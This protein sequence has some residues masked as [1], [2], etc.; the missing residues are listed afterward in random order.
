MYWGKRHFQSYPWRVDLPIWQAVVAEFFLLRTRASQVVP[1]FERFRHCYPDT[2]TL[3]G[4]G[5]AELAALVRPLG[6]RWREPLFYQL[7]LALDDLGD[8]LADDPDV[9]RSLPGVGEYVAAATASLHG[10]RRAVILDSNV[11]RLLSRLV[12]RP[13]DGET[14]RKRWL[15]DLADRVTPRLGY[16]SFNYAALDLAMSICL[17]RNPH[18]EECPVADI[19]QGR[20]E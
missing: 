5:E 8:G 6:L 18:C 3:V 20:L 17:P 9:L 11:V 14:R 13:Y 15:R 12:D 10:G 19:C 7:A 16:R 4:A 1:V 2:S